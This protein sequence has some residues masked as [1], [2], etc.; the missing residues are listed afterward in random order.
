[1]IEWKEDGI[2]YEADQ[3][4]AEIIIGQ[5]NLGDESRS[6]NT[7]GQKVADLEDEEL[8]PEESR[9]YRG[10]VARANYLGQ[11]RSDIQYAVK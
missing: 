9:M 10:M 8:T 6:V 7:P 11:D 5:M 3:R 2:H 1:M 4:H